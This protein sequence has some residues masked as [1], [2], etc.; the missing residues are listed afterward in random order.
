MA[1]KFTLHYG[2]SKT[3]FGP[4]L[5][6]IN[7]TS[8]DIFNDMMTGIKNNIGVTQ[9]PDGFVLSTKSWPMNIIDINKKLSCDQCVNHQKE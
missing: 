8:C 2:T 7:E 3:V 4:C 6:E 5:C 9:V 1:D